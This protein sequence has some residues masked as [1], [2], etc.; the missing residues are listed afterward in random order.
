MPVTRRNFLKA[1]GAALALAPLAGSAS[2]E[3][4]P[5]PAK[6]KVIYDQDNAG[7][8]STDTLAQLLFMQA[9]NIDL[10]GITL[11]TGDQWLKQELAYTLRLLEMMGR[12]DVPVYAGAEL[13]MLNTKEEALLRYEL[14]GG[15]RLDPWLG[16]FNRSNGGPNE[17]KPLLP[18]YDRFASLTPEREHA[19]H[20]II[21]TVREHPGEVTLYCGGPLTNV[22]LAVRLAPDIVPFVQEVVFMGTGL[23]YF[24]NSFN[25]FFDPEAAKIVL[26]APWPKLTLVTVDLGELIHLG[27]ELRPGRM[28]VEEIAE[29]AP[30][31]I[32]D[33]FREH[34]IKPYQRNPKMRW[35][36]MPD[37]MAA[38]QIIDPSIFTKAEEMYV[39][40]CSSP[41]ARYGDSMFWA[42]NWRAALASRLGASST[43]ETA[44]TYGI[45]RLS[46]GS[47]YA[48]PP[49]SAGRARVLTD[50][51]RD[52]FK[53][54]FV[55][56]LTRPIRRA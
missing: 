20:F 55:D 17:V 3:P 14:Y 26:R 4:P 52:R 30:S 37:E 23:H 19:A 33:L 22:A 13:P 40:I 12:P 15:H 45:E 25:V 53:H 42:A 48:G 35:F 24:T 27:D 10:L 8:L 5:P 1:S 34:T 7:P 56:L 28:M 11:V 2:T 29:L 43:A 41:G 38:V 21:R 54:L 6:R 39:D 18:P 44:D 9:E 32:S 16:A 47:W 36:R 51:D 31:P 49:P 50:L 46:G